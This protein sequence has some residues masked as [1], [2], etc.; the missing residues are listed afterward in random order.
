[1]GGKGE[2]KI[3]SSH[4]KQSWNGRSLAKSK[5]RATY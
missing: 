2:M 5:K 3:Q 1:M 4:E